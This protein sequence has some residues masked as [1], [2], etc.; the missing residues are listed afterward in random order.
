MMAWTDSSTISKPQVVNMTADSRSATTY[1]TQAGDTLDG[2]A[3]KYG[4]QKTTVAWAN[5]LSSDALEPNVTLT[6][7]PTDGVLYTT[8]DDNILN[9]QLFQNGKSKRMHYEM[10]GKTK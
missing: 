8:K 1:V 10:I 6:I 9:T 3:E 7:L 2:V 4:L 5:N